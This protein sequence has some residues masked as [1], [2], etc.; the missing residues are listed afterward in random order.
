ML[1]YS[2]SKG[3]FA[4]IDLSGGMLQPDK[5]ALARAYGSG[6]TAR[7][8]V[9]GTA[10]VSAPPESAPFMAALRGKVGTTSERR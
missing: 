3:V 9:T 5:E 1:S 10:R 7:G 6:V 8:V 2:L 4:G